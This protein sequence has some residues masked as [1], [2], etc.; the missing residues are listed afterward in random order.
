[1]EPQGAPSGERGIQLEGEFLRWS[2]ADQNHA[3]A[4][5]AYENRRCK[6]CGT[7]PDEWAED[8][9]AYHAH[10]SE[11]Q[12][13]KHL[14]RLAATDEAKSGEGRSA[15]MAGGPAADCRRCRPMVSG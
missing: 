10:L 3:L 1:M 2:R 8:K 15:V 4:W 11:C 5:Q 13:C 12:G 6:S 7:H 14:Q 9:L